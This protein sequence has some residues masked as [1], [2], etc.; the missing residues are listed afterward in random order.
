[1][2]SRGKLQL[3]LL[4]GNSIEPVSIS[5]LIRAEVSGGRNLCLSLTSE[6]GSVQEAGALL[7]G[8]NRDRG[9]SHDFPPPTPPGIRVRT[10][11]VRYW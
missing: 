7:I 4:R 10:K 5:Y 6:Q 11:A 2:Y 3:N 8:L 1:M 9:K